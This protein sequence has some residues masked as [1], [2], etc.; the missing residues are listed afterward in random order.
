MMS[1]AYG[2]FHELGMD[3]VSTLVFGIVSIILMVLGFKAFDMITPELNVEKELA[4]KHNIAVAIV[5]A[6][7][8]L[9]ISV[10]VAHIVSTP[11]LPPGP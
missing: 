8:I 2:T 9:G 10:I 1:L 4:E 5:I 11:S 7:V 3:V 6:A